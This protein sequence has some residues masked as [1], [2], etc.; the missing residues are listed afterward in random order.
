MSDAY[1]YRELPGSEWPRSP[2]AVRYQGW[3]TRVPVAEVPWCAEH[4]AQLL[5]TFHQECARY[6]LGDVEEDH[7]CRLEEP[8]RHYVIGEAE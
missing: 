7:L 2:N 3:L 4:D 1:L 5:S 8:A 6:Q